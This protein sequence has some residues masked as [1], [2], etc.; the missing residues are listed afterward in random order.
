[1][2]A[3]EDLGYEALD[4]FP[5]SLIDALLTGKPLARP[6]VLGIDVRN[7]DFN[8]DG[9]LSVLKHLEDDTRYDPQLLFLDCAEDRL[10]ARFSET[11]RRHPLA[12]EDAPVVGIRRE[13]QLLPPVRERADF[14]IDTTQMTPHD[15]RDELLR[16]FGSEGN[17][18]MGVTLH[19][20]SFKRGLPS[21][22]DM[23]F[24][25]RFLRNPHWDPLLR[26]KDG[27]DDQVADFVRLD[28][29]FAPFEGHVLGL[30]ETLLPA[31]QE[32]GKTHL[33]VGFGCTGGKHR[34]V[35]MLETVYR[36]LAEKG[37]QVSKRHRE[38]E[39]MIEEPLSKRG[40]SS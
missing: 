27:R 29:R 19:S 24:D 23:V 34:S 6:L 5:L 1:M 2:N 22:L 21:G 7:R 33:S 17:A 8:V 10:V 32:E 14:V 20:F 36:A 37:W 30:M 16:W 25:C 28:E 15:L 4:N 9:L 13:M 11:R 35:M 40:P 26:E 3:L 38:L 39:R 31:F 18:I 12:L